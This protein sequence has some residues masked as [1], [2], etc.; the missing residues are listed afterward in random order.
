MN[1]LRETKYTRIVFELHWKNY[2]DEY[3]RVANSKNKENPKRQQHRSRNLNPL[4][5]D[6]YPKKDHIERKIPEPLEIKIREKLEGRKIGFAACPPLALYIVVYSRARIG[7]T[8]HALAWERM[9]WCACVFAR[10]TGKKTGWPRWKGGRSRHSSF[11]RQKRRRRN[12]AVA[13][14]RLGGQ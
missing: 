3:N 10:R 12:P 5:P 9:Y 6:S 1:P 13:G 14:E 2:L 4:I 8:A 11:S 7:Q